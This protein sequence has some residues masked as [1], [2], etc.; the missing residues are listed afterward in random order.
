MLPPIAAA[1]RWAAVSASA[2]AEADYRAVL[3]DA[4]TAY[5]SIC[6]CPPAVAQTGKNNEVDVTEPGCDG[7][8]TCVCQKPASA[9]FDHPWIVSRAGYRKFLAQHLHSCPRNPEVFEMYTFNDHYGYGQ[10]EMMQ[11][12]LL[13]FVGMEALWRE[14]W[15]IVEGAVLWLLDDEST[16]MLG[17][18]FRPGLGNGY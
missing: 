9:P 4:A 16:A 3:D 15:T 2:N 1:T 18:V 11:N 8:V 7:G 6:I 10:L 12:L 5:E 17:Y 14:Q 13:D